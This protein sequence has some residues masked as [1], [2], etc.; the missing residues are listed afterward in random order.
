M[1][2]NLSINHCSLEMSG[3]QFWVKGDVVSDSLVKHRR[4]PLECISIHLFL[5]RT[6]TRG[7]CSQNI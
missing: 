5:H 2:H 6:N 7:L 4:I 1:G 3:T